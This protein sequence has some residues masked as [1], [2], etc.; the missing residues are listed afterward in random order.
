MDHISALVLL[1]R[2]SDPPLACSSAPWHPRANSKYEEYSLVR[3]RA[4]RSRSPARST[5][6]YASGAALV[7]QRSRR[8]QARR[9]I[10][11]RDAE[12]RA[13]RQSE[14][15]KAVGHRLIRRGKDAGRAKQCVGRGGE[16]GDGDEARERR[17]DRPKRA[18]CRTGM[19]GRGRYRGLGE[20]E[21]ARVRSTLDETRNTR[22]TA[23]VH[24]ARSTLMTARALSK[25]CRTSTC[26]ACQVPRTRSSARD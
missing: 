22:S 23:R 2:R 19:W 6:H 14:R 1:P 18:A 24:R 5:D 4:P 8:G 21:G 10:R 15:V 17:A 11:S 20:G 16:D 13:V 3:A 7:L 12:H 25:R 26:G 9:E